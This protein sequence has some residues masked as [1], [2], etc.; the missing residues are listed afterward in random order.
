M[1]VDAQVHIWNGG[2]P[3]NPNHRQVVMGRAVCAWL[4]WRR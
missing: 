1:I 3:A 4:D 2:K